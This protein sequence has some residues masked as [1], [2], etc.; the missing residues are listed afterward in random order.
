MRSKVKCPDCGSV[1]YTV[2]DH[3]MHCSGDLKEKKDLGRSLMDR[4][5]S[6]LGFSFIF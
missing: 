3:C 1:N 5:Y 4:M 6:I 2:T